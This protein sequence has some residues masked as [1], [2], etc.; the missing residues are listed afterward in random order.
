[1]EDNEAQWSYETEKVSQALQCNVDVIDGS[2]QY[3]AEELVQL[4]DASVQYQDPGGIL[5]DL[6]PKEEPKI[7]IPQIVLESREV[8]C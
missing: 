6:E 4:Q 1:M 8:Q 3:E 7:V 2:M 5:E